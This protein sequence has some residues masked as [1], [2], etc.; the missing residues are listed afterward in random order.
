M[1]TSPYVFG[2]DKI[3]YGT[4]QAPWPFIAAIHF[5]L[6]QTCLK[7]RKRMTLEA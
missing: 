2:F 5:S 4:R 7:V 6:A 3:I 1:F